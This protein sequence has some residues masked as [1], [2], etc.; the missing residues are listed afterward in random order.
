MYNIVDSSWLTQVQLT[1]CFATWWIDAIRPRINRHKREG[2]RERE[3]RQK[4][5]D[6]SDAYLF[7]LSLSLSLSPF[8]WLFIWLRREQCKAL[9]VSAHITPPFLFI[10]FLRFLTALGTPSRHRNPTPTMLNLIPISFH[11]IPLY[12]IYWIAYTIDWWL[13][14][15]MTQLGIILAVIRLIILH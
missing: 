11:L 10:W 4:K 2:E 3:K 15:C 7:S 1:R 12:P 5:N 13:S 8:L 6:A 9:V 14:C